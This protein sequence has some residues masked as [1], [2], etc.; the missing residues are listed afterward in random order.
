MMVPEEQRRFATQ[1]V[2]QLRE[3]GFEAYWAG[4]CVRDQLLGRTPK[5]YDVATDA[6]PTQ[7]RELF[8]RR[9]TLAI[10]AAF[11]VI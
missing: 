1:V 10:G 2:Q 8:G 6:T 4:G 9:R 7:I 3:A 11:G 5:D